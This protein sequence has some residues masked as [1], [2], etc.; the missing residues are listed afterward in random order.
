ML[1]FS[2]LPLKSSEEGRYRSP[3]DPSLA[4]SCRRQFGMELTRLT[5][6]PRLPPPQTAN[7]VGLED[8]PLPQSSQQSWTLP[9]LAHRAWVALAH[10]SACSRIPLPKEASVPPPCPGVPSSL[11]GPSPPPPRPR[12]GRKE[13]ESP[14]YYSQ[15]ERA[16]ALWEGVGRAGPH[17]LGGRSICTPCDC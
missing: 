10:T 15:Q 9:P 7:S 3:L 8:G 17:F 11:Q 12:A 16:S 14:A 5:R 13:A 2:V 6:H 1:D 4:L